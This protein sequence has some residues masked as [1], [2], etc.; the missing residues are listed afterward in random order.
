MGDDGGERIQFAIAPGQFFRTRGHGLLQVQR[1]AIDAFQTRPADVPQQLAA[2]AELLHVG[3][4]PQVEGFL[5]GIVGGGA[6][7]D[8]HADLVVETADALEQLGPA[9]VGQTQ[10][11]H[12]HAKVS[13]LDVLQRLTGRSAAKDV[14]TFVLQHV[15]QEPQL[16]L[17]VFHHQ[18]LRNSF[19]GHRRLSS[20]SPLTCHFLGLMSSPV[21]GVAGFPNSPESGIIY[22]WRVV[23]GPSFLIF[24]EGWP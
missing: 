11:D 9:E 24:Q 4:C 3:E 23:V 16:R 5:H 6:G 20:K 14:K 7:V 2:V 13:L 17:I 12:G 10:V 15:A 8:D 1:I 22:M 18:H 19:R 21:L